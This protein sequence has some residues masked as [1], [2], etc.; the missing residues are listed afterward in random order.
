MNHTHVETL[1]RMAGEAES[2]ERDWDGVPTPHAESPTPPRSRRPHRHRRLAGAVATIGAVGIGLAIALIAPGIHRVLVPTQSIPSSPA[3]APG[4][5]PGTNDI[6]IAPETGRAS[7]MLVA[8]YRAA[9][10]AVSNSTPTLESCPKCWCLARWT[11]EQGAAALA[12]HELLSASMGK[13]CVPEPAEV[14]VIGL[15]GPTASLPSSDDQALSL[16]MCVL[17]TETS[18]SGTRCI[19][20]DVQVRIAS[21]RR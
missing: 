7:T 12:D 18:Q 19:G 10:D 15:S 5:F 17:D 16:A 14:I 13:T 6:A 1:L 21:W 4:L 3:R 2:L 9:S 8:L 20:D 11:P